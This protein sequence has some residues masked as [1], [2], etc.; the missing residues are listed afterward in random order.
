MVDGGPKLVTIQSILL[1]VDRISFRPGFFHIFS[2]QDQTSVWS[3]WRKPS[4]RYWSGASRIFLNSWSI[5]EELR[6]WEPRSSSSGNRWL[7]LTS[8]S[9][10]NR[11]ED[12]GSFKL[13]TQ[14]LRSVKKKHGLYYELIRVWYGLS[15]STR[16]AR[17]KQLYKLSQIVGFWRL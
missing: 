17:M 5:M 3:R 7:T 14:R 12:L 13:L 15:L 1:T 6:L 10:K 4:P 2:L 16:F 9:F 11:N 8:N